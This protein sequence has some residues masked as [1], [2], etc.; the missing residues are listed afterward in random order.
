MKR[1][2]VW[3]VAGGPDYAGKPRPVAI[4]QDDAFSSTASVTVCPFT[5]HIIDAPLMRLPVEPT[6]GNGLRT[7]SQLMADKITTVAKTKLKRRLGALSTEEI[8]G[9]NRAMVVLLGLAGRSK[10]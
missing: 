5:T 10:E 4:V 8:T 7:P 6:P 3:T 1:G 9:L 2:E